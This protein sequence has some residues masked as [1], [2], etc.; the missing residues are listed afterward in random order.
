MRW[1]STPQHYDTANKRA[2]DGR[3]SNVGDRVRQRR[4]RN[5]NLKLIMCANAK[6]SALRENVS[7][8]TQTRLHGI[9]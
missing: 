2:E 6:I 5:Y 8:K 1:N 7:E 4:K 9:N 3:K